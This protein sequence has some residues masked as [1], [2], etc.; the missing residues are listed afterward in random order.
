M[1]LRI[2]KSRIGFRA[3]R[4]PTRGTYAA[5]F[6]ICDLILNRIRAQSGRVWNEVAR[7]LIG[8]SGLKSPLLA[9]PSRSDTPSSLLLSLL[10]SALDSPS[11]LALHGASSFQ[12]F[13][14]SGF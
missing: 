3:R 12:A 10:L 13:R 14:L 1:C 7:L 9:Q 4:G 5:Y 11:P 8:D 2:R 6:S